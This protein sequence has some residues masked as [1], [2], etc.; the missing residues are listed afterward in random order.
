MEGRMIMDCLS[1]SLSNE[2]C[3]NSPPNLLLCRFSPFLLLPRSQLVSP[4]LRPVHSFHSSIEKIR[5][6]WCIHIFH[7]DEFAANSFLL[8]QLYQLLWKS[9]NIV[10]QLSLLV[11]L[12]VSWHFW[13]IS[14]LW[15]NYLFCPIGFIWLI[16]SPPLKETQI[17]IIVIITIFAIIIT[18]Q[19]WEFFL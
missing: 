10:S 1:Q 3:H 16:W 15:L 2:N 7:A 5:L 17:T 11:H 8:L 6:S 13:T 14:F 19:L 18:L 4:H 9:R 12:I